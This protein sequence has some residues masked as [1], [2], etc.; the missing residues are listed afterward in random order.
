MR[1]KLFSWVLLCGVALFSAAVVSAAQEQIAGKIIAAKVR[2]TVTA[3]NKA[4]NTNRELHDSDAISEGYVVTTAQKS[5]VVLIFANGSAVNLASD[6]TLAI[7]E[8]LM[9]PFDPKYS[10]ADAKDEPSISTTKLSLQH[11]ELV[12]NVKHLH[13]DQGSSFTVNTPVGAAG[14]R[15]TTFQFSLGTDDAGNPYVRFSTSEGTVYLTALDGTERLIPAGKAVSVTFATT[16]NAAGETVVVPG[17]VKVTGV[18]D[19]PPATQAAIAQAVQAIVE[20]N[21]NIANP[22]GNS[23]NATTPPVNT[24]PGDG[25]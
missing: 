14:I 23:P 11:G 9:D 16:T 15:G 3:H 13:R 10:A 24:T 25:H 12:G 6:S 17:S 20:A 1:T 22:G 8:F 21:P 2:G 7:D 4:D 5:S 19:M 18:E